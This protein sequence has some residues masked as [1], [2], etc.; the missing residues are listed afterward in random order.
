MEVLVVHVAEMDACTAAFESLHPTT[1]LGLCVHLIKAI[2]L[3]RVL[4]KCLRESGA[5]VLDACGC[6]LLHGP[7]V[8]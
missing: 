1:S 7:G 4:L 6:L 5:P 3:G 2:T 8:C